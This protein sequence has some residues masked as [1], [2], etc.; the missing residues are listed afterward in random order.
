MSAI[1]WWFEHSLALPFFGIGMKTDQIL[2]YMCLF[3]GGLGRVDSEKRDMDSFSGKLT[4][5]YFYSE[6]FYAWEQGKSLQKSRLHRWSLSMYKV[7]NSKFTKLMRHIDSIFSGSRD[8]LLSSRPAC[9]SQHYSHTVL[10][11]YMQ[12]MFLRAKH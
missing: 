5:L 4:K 12:E 2:E 6:S 8:N 1:V 10:K 3:C 11:S 9:Y 7:N